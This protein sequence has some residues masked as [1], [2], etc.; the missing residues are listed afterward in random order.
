MLIGW[1]FLNS[2]GYAH[3]ENK[4]EKRR[5]NIFH[6]TDKTIDFI[7]P[8][9]MLKAFPFVSNLIIHGQWF[10]II[11]MDIIVD[12]FYSLLF[13][14]LSFIFPKGHVCDGSIYIVGDFSL[15]YLC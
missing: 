15:R 12:P 2:Q 14:G 7:L 3:Y 6:K 10:F 13:D 4:K 5:I 8:Q 9:Q 1:F 11:L